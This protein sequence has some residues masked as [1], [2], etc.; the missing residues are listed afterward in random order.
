MNSI[1]SKRI[2][3]Y[4]KNNIIKFEMSLNKKLNTIPKKFNIEQ[5]L[6]DIYTNLIQLLTANDLF[7]QIQILKDLSDKN[8]NIKKTKTKIIIEKIKEIIKITVIKLS[9]LYKEKFQMCNYIL[10]LEN[11]IR[12]NTKEILENKV[13]K[14]LY[15]FKLQ[16]FS[17][18]NKEY[19]KLKDKVKYKKGKF[20]NDDK[21]ENEIFILRQ[22]NSNLK[23]EI[24]KLQEKI[25]EYK[26]N[27]IV[28]N[29]IIINSYNKKYTSNITK[30]RSKTKSHKHML[31]TSY[32]NS[33]KI[34]NKNLN[35]ENDMN[36][37]M[38]IFYKEKTKNRVIKNI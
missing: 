37:T 34:I 26:I 38:N 6:F 1:L 10:K 15:L 8:Y 23:S 25:N 3:K 24:S 21:K 17:Q 19:E 32:N 33:K 16:K 20:L 30:N 12:K 7:K 2:K 13:E 28:N 35:K 31:N 29:N 9:E 4:Y 22:E 36:K 5:E 18:I 27:K 11:D 14:E